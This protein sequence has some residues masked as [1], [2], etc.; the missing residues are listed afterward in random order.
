LSK[1]F[2]AAVLPVYLKLSRSGN[3]FTAYQS[4]D[5]LNWNKLM[6]LNFQRPFASGYFTGMAVSSH[7]SQLLNLTKFTDVKTG[8]E[9]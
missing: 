2:P 7:D 3:M 9:N 1:L 8:T 4:A 5:G 6:D